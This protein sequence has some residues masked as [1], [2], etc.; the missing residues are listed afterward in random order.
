[1]LKKTAREAA[2]EGLKNNVNKSKEMC[3]AMKN[4]ETLRIYSETME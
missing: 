1:V 3:I 4:D 2:K